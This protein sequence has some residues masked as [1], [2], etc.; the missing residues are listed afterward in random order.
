MDIKITKLEERNST[1]GL[2]L[3]FT[4]AGK[5]FQ[6]IPFFFRK[7]G[8]QPPGHMH[9]GS[10]PA[11]DPQI[12]GLLQGKL[13]F[14]ITDLTEHTHEYILSAGEMISIPKNYFHEYEVLEDAIFFEPRTTIYNQN[15]PNTTDYKR[16]KK[17]CDAQAIK[18]VEEA[19]QEVRLAQH[20]KKGL[21][22]LKPLS[23]FFKEHSDDL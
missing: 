11:N 23:E 17:L 8:Q 2:T 6:E 22:S 19:M 21:K 16:F 5:N 13:K 14:L 10:D 12:I 3:N 15:N 9:T 18:E 7:A 4:C 1:K 20:S